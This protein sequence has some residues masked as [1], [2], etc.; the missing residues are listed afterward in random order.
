MFKTE[1]G[2]QVSITYDFWASFVCIKQVFV[3]DLDVN[4]RLQFSKKKNYSVSEQL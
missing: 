4:V 3:H 2:R 1:I